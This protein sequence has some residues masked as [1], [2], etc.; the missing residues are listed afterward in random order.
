MN[1]MPSGGGP[2]GRHSFSTVFSN[3][4]CGPPPEQAPR[5]S[6]NASAAKSA[7]RRIADRLHEERD[8]PVDRLGRRGREVEAQRARA[9]RLPR[10]EVA[11]GDERDA[12]LERR[13]EDPRRVRA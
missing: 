1:T 7:R 12:A 8:A 11:P 3:G 13:A 4:G 10:V 6:A 9:L 2:S 5:A